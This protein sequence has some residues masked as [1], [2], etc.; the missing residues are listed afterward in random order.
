MSLWP[1][2]QLGIDCLKI[3]SLPYT[4]ICFNF[5]LTSTM[6]LPLIGREV[7]DERAKVFRLDFSS[8]VVVS[9]VVLGSDSALS[10]LTL[11][12]NVTVI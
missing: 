5:Y 2:T 8:C 3:R 11:Y 6:N 1:L 9:V 7:G 12:N 4:G 10:N